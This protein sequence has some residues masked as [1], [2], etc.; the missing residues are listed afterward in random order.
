MED[1]LIDVCSGIGAEE[2][3]AA[4]QGLTATSDHVRMA[5]LSA[6]E[7]VPALAQGEASCLEGPGSRRSLAALR[8]RRI[9]CKQGGGQQSDSSQMRSQHQCRRAPAVRPESLRLQALQV[10]TGS[11]VA[12]SVLDQASI[13]CRRLPRRPCS[14][15]SVVAGALRS[16]R[17]QRRGG[18]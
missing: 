6:L 2:L 9:A 10:V 3:P 13:C 4:L 16:F 15:C 8:T 7:F 11:S 18:N 17:G 5:A 12:W 14:G 1:L